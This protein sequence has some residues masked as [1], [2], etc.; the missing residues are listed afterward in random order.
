[1]PS[2]FAGKQADLKSLFSKN[3]VSIERNERNNYKEKNI[4]GNIAFYIV[5]I[6]S[7]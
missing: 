2:L 7:S 6:T 5:E 3:P 4:F 1:M